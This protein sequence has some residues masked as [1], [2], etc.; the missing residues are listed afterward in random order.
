MFNRK[1]Y[2]SIAK[3]QLKGRK[4]TTVISTLIVF[5]ISLLIS[6][7][8][9]VPASLSTFIFFLS[10]AINGILVIAQSRLYLVYF[11]TREQV[12][13]DEFLKGFSLWIKGALACLWYVMWVFLWSLLFIIP[14]I[15]KAISYS[16][17]FFILAENPGLEVNKAM[18][19]SKVMTHGH[20][21][22][23]FVMGL[24]FIGWELLACLTLGILQLWITPYQ[25]M[26]YTNAYKGMKI[27][28]LRTGVLTQE[29]FS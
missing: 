15:V 11:Q 10:L 19:I 12:Q 24:S 9:E 5:L 21:A 1:E 7:S 16:Q 20:K 4:S 23:L 26:S 22:D 28:A 18:K 17:M 8:P 3:K 2:K 13:F 25:F 29:D 6:A 14:G 27:E